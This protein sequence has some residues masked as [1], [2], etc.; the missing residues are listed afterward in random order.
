MTIWI[1]GKPFSAREGMLLDALVEAGAKVPAPCGGNGR[2]GKC[3][4]RIHDAGEPTAQEI[5]LLN[6]AQIAQGWRLACKTPVC[7]G[8][9]VDTPAEKTG[10]KIAVE[11]RNA[12]YAV[13]PSVRVLPF[14]LEKPHIGDQRDDA[15]RLL[16]ALDGAETIHPAALAKLPFALRA[17]DFA[18]EAVVC[19]G[20]VLDVIAPQQR[21][22]GVAVD[23][24]TT[25]LAAYLVDLRRGAQLAST[26]RLNPQK[27]RGDDVITRCDHAKSQG[28]DE[29]QKMVTSAVGDMA[30]QMCGQVQAD[31]KQIYEMTI[32]GNT[33][34]L[35]LFA[36]ISPENIAQAPFVPVWTREMLLESAALAIALNPAAKILLLP[37]V[38]GYVGADTVAAML[39]CGMH[40]HTETSLLIDI[41]TNGEIALCTGEKIYACSTAAGPAFEG[42]H[43]R[44]GV[45]SVTGAINSVKVQGEKLSYTTIGDGQPCGICGSGLVDLA[46][47]LLA[48]GALDVTG[49]MDEEESD[50][51]LRP[52]FTEEGFFP[53]PEQQIG[54]VQK[55]IRELQLAKGAIAAGVDVLLAAAGIPVG[56]VD[57]LYLAGG[58]G[59]YMDKD[60]AAAI[61]LIPAALL[62]K[63]EAVGNAAGTG[64]KAVLLSAQMEAQA[65][66]LA[67]QTEYIELS[68]RPEF[69]NAFM[70]KMMFE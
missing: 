3:L 41:G 32:A 38:A 57:H 17:Q 15:R 30:A 37:C 22:L 29:L 8:M 68:A 62:K 31:A 42:A 58:F 50:G 59:T 19:R 43:I 11:G 2:C 13:E 27:A 34:M 46:A 63:T 48:H 23:I 36:G 54:I 40:E 7:E 28:V 52:Y 35:H 47:V 12:L 1:D 55:D 61:G 20:E 67:R 4:V 64:A 49:M 6:P 44:C 70:D 60:S 51:A 5:K 25:T 10:A 56:Q 45:G 24:G 14:A 65:R 21:V 69:Q 26:S 53:A 39:S 33:V 16:E 9:R 66:A 18:G